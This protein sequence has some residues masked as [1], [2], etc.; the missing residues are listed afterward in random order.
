MNVRTSSF[1][2]AVVL[3]LTSLAACGKSAEDRCNDV[4]SSILKDHLKMLDKGDSAA[5]KLLREQLDAKRKQMVATCVERG[6]PTDAEL[7]CIEKNPG[8]E[9][10]LLCLRRR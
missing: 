6:G 5:V 2:A 10:A 7:E 3:A 1:I 8:F 4:A 9:G